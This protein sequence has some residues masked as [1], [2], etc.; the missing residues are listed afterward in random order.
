MSEKPSEILE[1]TKQDS[2]ENA[3][4][5]TDRRRRLAIFV[6]I[7]IVCLLALIVTHRSGITSSLISRDGLLSGWKDVP[8]LSLL[9][10]KKQPEP[11]Q[12]GEPPP[13]FTRTDAESLFSPPTL[14]ENMGRSATDPARVFFP[15]FQS[16]PG[17]EN[18]SPPK[19]CPA[20]PAVMRGPETDQPTVPSAR[21]SV[22]Q[23]E[24]PPA[25]S[26]P[27]GRVVQ[28][29]R[30]LTREPAGS[31]ASDKTP[32]AKIASPDDAEQDSPENAPAS[33][34]VDR[35]G[36]IRKPRPSVPTGDET[37]ASDDAG[38]V[39][40]P[41]KKTPSVEGEAADEQYRL[42]G[43]LRVEVSNYKGTKV[44]WEL[45]VI[46]D[47]SAAM[48]AKPKSWPSGRL[49]TALG[50]VARIGEA[51]TPGSRIAVRDFLCKPG[52]EKKRVVP[53]CLSHLFRPWSSAPAKGLAKE[54]EKSQPAGR[55]NPCAAA[56]YSLKRD[57]SDAADRTS[58][59]V[60][61]TGGVTPCALKEVLNAIERKG[62]KGKIPVDVIALG[63]SPRRRKGYS[64]LTARTGGVFLKVE[65]PGGVNSVI[66]RY[67][68][69]LQAPIFEKMVVKGD[70]TSFPIGN[71]EEITLAP[72]TY[73][74]L[75]PEVLGLKPAERSI[76]NIVI[77]SG[78]T[79]ILK[80]K[81]NKGRAIVSTVKKL[82]SEKE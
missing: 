28:T 47:N 22:P 2:T 25:V 20:P 55:T 79:N 18:T 45:M 80:I 73:T 14:L 49:P 40:A 19:S 75:L 8:I 42:P 52:T 27:G 81:I 23:E 46:L 37:P 31:P 33:P 6:V 67:R 78:Q 34:T 66:A 69:L 32:R 29:P 36:P 71:N 11:P 48:D 62:A 61:L 77:A 65:N 53:L 60:I 74:L 4:R 26:P 39:P 56:A 17:P 50:F 16:P 41:D 63:M 82:S 54:L 30:V 43:S 59:L 24:K 1:E 9:S 44:K 21:E 15:P 68:D 38:G 12:S 3:P 57:F 70:K 51:L 5:P 7:V 64:S 35:P 10:A 72:A 76:K 58:R 13:A